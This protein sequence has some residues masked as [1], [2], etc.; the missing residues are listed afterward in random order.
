M[1]PSAFN[2]CLQA[3]DRP[4]CSEPLLAR[5]D[6]ARVRGGLPRGSFAHFG[7]D[8]W[9]YRALLPFAGH[10][11]AVR[12][13]EGGT[14]LLPLPRVAWGLGLER[15]WLKEGLSNPTESVKAH[16]LAVAVDGTIAFGV[17]A[18][19]VPSAGNG[20][21][22]AAGLR[23]RS[24]V[25]ADTRE[26]F[27]IE[28]PACGA[29]VRLAHAGGDSLS[30]R[31]RHQTGRDVAGLPRAGRVRLDDRPAAGADGRADGGRRRSWARGEVEPQSRV[32]ICDTGSGLKYPEAWRAALAR[33]PLEEAS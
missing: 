13:G 27:V 28:Q 21:S 30:Y 7:M 31:R 12:L 17:R 6:L 15:L 32:V 23:C 1:V 20:G 26:V 22:T 4:V 25:P 16:G 5:C 33:R 29:E 8:L 9:R 19:A 18:V 24:T 10:L 2:R 3:L 11:P 14:P